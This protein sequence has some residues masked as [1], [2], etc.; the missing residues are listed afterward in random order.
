MIGARFKFPNLDGLDRD[1]CRDLIKSTKGL[2]NHYK[3][4]K[5]AFK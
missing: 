2:I 3:N 4:Y 1:T 5:N